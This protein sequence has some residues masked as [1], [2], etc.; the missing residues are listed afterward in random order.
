VRLFA[1][2][3]GA[4]VLAGCRLDVDV[5]VDMAADGSGTVT[6]TATADAELVAKAPTAVQDLRLEDAR[7]AGWTVSGPAPVEG[8]GSQVVLT[9]GFASPEQATAILAEIN[10]PG[11]PLSGLTLFQQREFAKLT[12]DVAGE[13]RLVGGMAAFADDALVQ[14]AGK[15]PLADQVAASGVPLDQALG[16]TVS[17]T[18][19][20]DVTAANGTADGGTVTWTPSLVDGQVTRLQATAVQ[21]DTAAVQARS[22][23]RWTTWAL[24]AWGVLFALIVLV[25]L[26]RAWRRRHAA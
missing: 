15:V 18:L 26:L 12:S 14:V 19:P 7:D 3:L 4:V 24:V 9:K 25:V 17:V 16:L 10:G 1:L 20:G 11:G 6:V 23:E 2:A 5:A 13:V 8:G 22:V 21:E